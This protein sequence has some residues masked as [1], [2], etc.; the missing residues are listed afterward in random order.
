MA[1]SDST[2]LRNQQPQCTCKIF[3][4]LK[5]RELIGCVLCYSATEWLNCFSVYFPAPYTSEYI[6]HVT[7]LAWV[8]LSLLSSGCICV[9]HHTPLSFMAKLYATS[10]SLSMWCWWICWWTYS[11]FPIFDSFEYV[12]YGCLVYEFFGYIFSFGSYIHRLRLLVQSMERRPSCSYRRFRFDFQ[13]PHGGSQE[14][15]S[16][17]PGDLLPSCYL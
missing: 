4:T 1:S 14:C 12:G 9:M 11:L 8:F 5:H 13:H 6:C 10:S 7:M 15:I 3:I 16:P 2:T 17:V